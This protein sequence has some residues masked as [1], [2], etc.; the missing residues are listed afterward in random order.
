MIVGFIAFM[1]IW[2]STRPIEV[3]MAQVT[4]GPIEEY[5][6]EE[7]VTQLDTERVITAE[8]PGTAHRI[9]LEEGD[10]VHKD[11]V[12]ATI[13]DTTLRLYMDV[14]KAQI[15]E[16]QAQL[17]GVDVPL[18]K[19]SEIEAAEKE[20]VRAEAE[21]QALVEDKHAAD[22][23][24]KRA[25]SE[26]KRIKELVGKGTAT[27]QQYELA[28]R[29]LQVAG[30]QVQSLTHRLE[31]A[32]TAATVAGLR[33]RVLEESMEDTAHLR[34]AYGA[35]IAQTQKEIE[36]LQH[37]L[38]KAQVLS[39]I[40]GVVLTKHLDSEQYVQQGTPLLT[41]GDIDSVEIRSD[42]LSDE[43]G[44]IRV[45][46]SVRLVGPALPGKGARGR[47]RKIYPSGFTKISSLGV[48]QQRVA[49]LID[50]DN[51]GLHLK[52]GSE[53]DVKIVVDE[54]ADT[55]RVPSAAVFAEAE[56]VA[57]FV[58]EAGRARLRRVEIGLRGDDDYEVTAGLQDGETVILRP[59]AGLAVGSRVIRPRDR[60][61]S[62]RG[63]AD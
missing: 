14:L 48:R 17:A 13:E 2:Q 62:S 29:D 25:E 1:W 54:R 34:E 55:V 27:E 4:R 36:I 26:F 19:P 63:A 47:V 39:P 44:R 32:K 61:L 23:E 56:G 49:V 38:G 28:E 24:L 6:T 37:E 42:I 15:D 40:D 30:A 35:Q 33:K 50:F 10:P 59:P 21:V 58:V 52:P 31:A 51:S 3:D 18:P 11:D 20:R 45:G 46:Q 41:V 43:I 9:E 7:A 8:L 22:A 12:V 53:L 16:T 57:V 60:E 5:V